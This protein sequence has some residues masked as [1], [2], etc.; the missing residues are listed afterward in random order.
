M[1]R[2]M[3]SCLAYRNGVGWLA[4]VKLL[5]TKDRLSFFDARTHS[6]SSVGG[7]Y[8][9]EKSQDRRWSDPLRK[10]IVCEVSTLG[11]KALDTAVAA[12]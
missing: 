5:S 7:T 2:S 10:E 11:G 4:R 12:T 3:C 9:K 8:L 6:L 1:F